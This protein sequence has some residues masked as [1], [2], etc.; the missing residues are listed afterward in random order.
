MKTK[1]ALLYTVWIGDDMD[2]LKRS[3]E[4]HLPF[5]DKVIICFQ[6][7]SNKGEYSHQD[8]PPLYGNNKLIY[9]PFHPNLSLSTKQ[10]ERNK[11]NDMIEVAKHSGCT[12]FILSAADHFYSK[13]MFDYG[14]NV[15]QTTDADVILTRMRTYYKQDNWILDPIEEYYMPFIHKLTVNTEITTRVKYPVVVDPSVKVSTAQKFHIASDEYLMDHYSMMRM[16]IEKK[17]RNA[18]SSI[19]WTKEDVQTFINEYQNA[20]VGDSIKYFQG[21][22]IVEYTKDSISES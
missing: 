22:K 14:K 15:M 4:N 17:F 5:V 12:H 7:V 8:L 11:H 20:K 6:Q 10:N 1:T 9:T 18:A 13:E 21:R 3:I 2:M 19:R 16:D